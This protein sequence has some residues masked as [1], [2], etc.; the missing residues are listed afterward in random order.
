MASDKLARVQPG[1][2]AGPADTVSL[3]RT[4]PPKGR[5]MTR[6]PCLREK[7]LPHK[8]PIPIGYTGAG[9]VCAILRMPGLKG[10]ISPSRVIAPSGKIATNSPF[11]S[12]CRIV[13]K[14]CSNSAG[15]VVFEAIG[16][17]PAWRKMKDKIGVLKT[18]ALITNRTGRGESAKATIVR[19]AHVVEGDDS[20]AFN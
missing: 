10:P 9:V 6:P 5:V 3:P 2:I 16:M 15:S 17:A 4:P 14:A 1:G 7:K 18:S 8:P 11:S 20:R 13:S 12:A 19:E